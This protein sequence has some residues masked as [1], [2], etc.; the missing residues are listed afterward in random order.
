MN[1]ELGYIDNIPTLLDCQTLMNTINFSL[2]AHVQIFFLSFRNQEYVYH[3]V[4]KAAPHP[5]QERLAAFNH[6]GA[7]PPPAQD[8]NLQARIQPINNIIWLLSKLSS[9]LCSL[10]L[11]VVRNG[12]SLFRDQ[13]GS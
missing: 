8:H 6:T 1:F 11:F 9:N 7:F 12:S 13:F 2:L 4:S 10:C 5:E 3:T